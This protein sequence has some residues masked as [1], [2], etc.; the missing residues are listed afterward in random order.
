MTGSKLSVI[1]SSATL[2]LVLIASLQQNSVFAKENKDGRAGSWSKG[3][4]GAPDLAASQEQVAKNPKNAE[5]LNDLGFALRQNGKLAEAEQRLKE[6]LSIDPNMAAAHCNLSV[7]YYD[8]NK[9]DQAKEAAQ[10]AVNADAKQPIFHVVLGNALAGSGDRKA[11]IE[12]YKAAIQLKGDYE[13]AHYNLGRVL[14][15]DGQVNEARFALAK[16]LQLDPKDDRVVALLDKIEQ[17]GSAV[18]KKQ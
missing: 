11:A 12:Q 18:E 6:A 1:A 7:V 16:A 2:S 10:K 4:Q 14:N 13:N 8:Q 9:F 3:A 5:A 15:E 17:S